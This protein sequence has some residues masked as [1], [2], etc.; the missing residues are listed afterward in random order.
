[1][2]VLYKAALA[3]SISTSVV[4]FVLTAPVTTAQAVTIHTY[5]LPS[6]PLA[7]SLRDI[8]LASGTSIGAAAEVIGARQAPALDGDFTAR[9]AVAALLA[10]SGLHLRQIPT[11]L[12]VEADGT[13][14]G[15]GAERSGENSS[16]ILVTGSRIRGAPVASPTI[17]L[18][19]SAMRDAGATSLGDVMRSLPQSFGGG[20]NPGIGTNVPSASG[21]NVGSASTINLRGLGSDATLTLLDG[22]RLAYNGT[23]QG[24]DLSA[25]PF[26]M[27]DRVEVVADGASALY[28]SDAVAGVANIVLK[29]DVEGLE[30]RADLGGA[31]DGGD[32]QQQYG[33]V[34]GHKWNTGG[35]VA[36]YEYASNTAILSND[37]S[38]SAARPGILL[39]PALHHHAVALTGHQEITDTLTFDVDA[40]YNKRWSL[41]GYANNNAGDSSVSHT[42]LKATSRSVAVAPSL[43]LDLANGWRLSLSGFYGTETVR[44]ENNAYT[45]ATQTS[46]LGICY[47][48]TGSSVEL[49]G[50]GSLFTLPGGPVKLAIGGGYRSNSLDVFRAVGSAVNLTASQ[51][52]TYA[53]GELSVPVVSAMQGIGGID[54]LNLSGA[55]RYERYP[56]VGSVVTPK[57]G[58]I[59]APVPDLAIKGSWGRS[60][61]AP[62]LNQQ[63]A[64]RGISLYSASALGGT[65]YPSTAQIMLVSGGNP[66]LKPERAE[67]WTASLDYQPHQIPGLRLQGSYFVTLYKDRI[68]TPITYTSQ[69]LSNPL[70]A[71]FLSL[72]PSAGTIATTYAGAPNFYNYTTAAY[73]PTKVAAIVDD[74][75][76]NVGRQVIHG[77]DLLFDYGLKL[78]GEGGRLHVTGDVAYLSSRQQLIPGAVVTGM[79][80]TIFNPP[81]W[82]GQGS[83]TWSGGGVTLNATTRVIGGVSD[84]RAAPL[85]AV[86]GMVTQDVTIGYAF[87]QPRGALH[88]LAISLTA[89]NILNDRPT[90][91]AS[92][93]YADP[94]YDGTNYSPVGR[95]IG[96]GLVKSW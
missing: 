25:I 83:V 31:T 96:A 88:G 32:V 94:A 48:N 15:E 36:A 84:V 3:A 24:I 8:A 54:H 16:D 18:A 28:G 80:G 20:Q 62:T 76:V 52:S 1:M 13:Q 89:Q 14:V 11:G 53:Y 65:G 90:T 9:A 57:F 58:I 39:W 27:V 42:D 86:A 35:L 64:I 23:R 5:H 21:I 78:G 55:L 79:A 91:V 69:S 56:G 68:V 6:Q 60:F 72:A 49:A 4:G 93:T 70:Y 12:V 46:S 51:D 10:G 47:C 77:V 74:T 85:V 82:K 34:A 2:G 63:Y 45:G 40:L 19:Q 71:M 22:H 75:N 33:V 50:D 73:D 66:N 43:K 67:S 59:Y 87:R 38:F 44:L 26:G 61:R 41:G 30:T 81:H 95:Y 37:R 29:R 7:A 92:S 17:V